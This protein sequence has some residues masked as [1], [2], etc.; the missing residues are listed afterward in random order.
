MKA[1]RIIVTIVLVANIFCLQA[2][3]ITIH[4]VDGT[5]LEYH[6]GEVDSIVNY[7]TIP[8]TEKHEAVDLGLSV[9]WATCNV[10]ASQPY[11]KGN[12]YAWGE[13][14][15]KVN[16][17][18]DNHWFYNKETSS[19][20][21]LGQDISGTIYDAARQE[22]GGNWRMPTKEEME[23]LIEMCSWRW[24][25][26]G[27][28]CA[29]LV[30]GPNGNYIYIPATQYHYNA[31]SYTNTY[32]YSDSYWTSDS[33]NE[34]VAYYLDIYG[35]YNFLN[36]LSSDKNE[37]KTKSRIYTSCIRPVKNKE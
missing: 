5:K 34:N 1:L 30:T 2:Q 7:Q 6:C 27:S 14:E 23:E 25:R 36:T 11:Q 10:G 8:E 18:Y 4:K 22:W 19:Y 35:Y 24:V 15:A 33:Y 28:T 29:Y 16:G 17:W 9:L 37:L 3:T 26:I 32:S 31:N 12:G 20:K 13:T 21:D